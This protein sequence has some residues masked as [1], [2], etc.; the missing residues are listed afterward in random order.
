YARSGWHEHFRRL[1]SST[2]NTDN[3]PPSSAKAAIPPDEVVALARQFLGTPASPSL[4]YRFWAKDR[5][6]RAGA[7][8]PAIACAACGIDLFLSEWLAQK[9]V[10]PDTEVGWDGSLL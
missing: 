8:N 9:L 7:K 10:D 4:H 1:M 2:T 3:A 5:H 6:W